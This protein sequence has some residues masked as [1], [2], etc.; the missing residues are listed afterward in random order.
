MNANGTPCFV[1]LWIRG[2]IQRKVTSCFGKMV[3]F[4]RGDGKLKASNLM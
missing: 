4:V 1:R 2:A 3:T